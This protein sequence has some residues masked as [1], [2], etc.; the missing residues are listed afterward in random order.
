MSV[1]YS[2]LF[3]VLFVLLLPYFLVRALTTGRYRQGLAQRFGL[4]VPRVREGGDWIWIHAVSVGEVE[5]AAVVMRALRERMPGVR[6]LVTTTTSTGQE[7]AARQEPDLLRYFPLDFPW[8]ARRLLRAV[9]PRAI[10][11]METEI[12]PNFVAAASRAG[13]PLAILNGRISDSSFRWY[14]RVR[15]FLRGTMGRITLLAMQ[16]PLDGERARE[17]GARPE[18]VV[19]TGNL[20][21]DRVASRAEGIDAEE[22]RARLGLGGRRVVAAGSTHGEEGPR[23]LDCFRALRET[24]PELVLLL[25]PRHL[26]DLESLES[27]ALSLGLSVVRRSALP[28]PPDDPRGSFAVILGD[29]MGELAALYSVAEVAFVGGSMIE[30][31]GQN[32]LEPAALGVP[33]VHGPHMS[34]F[35]AARELLLNAGG[36]IEVADWGELVAALRRLLTDAEERRRRGAAGREAVMASRGAL[37][38]TMALLAERLGLGA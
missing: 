12:W 13:T 17:L 30:W 35:R 19:V 32:I 5:V 34:N 24:F 7:V 26:R 16:S 1:L 22:W 4:S 21:V 10:L 25:V 11:C 36:A 18:A 29:T 33:V 2:V 20:K 3:C 28:L 38:R 9:R 23:M 6:L 37:E 27:H 15:P 14:R 31:G 8:G